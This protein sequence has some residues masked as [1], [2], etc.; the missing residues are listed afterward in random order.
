MFVTALTAGLD[1]GEGKLRLACAGHPP[2]IVVG[3]PA[4]GQLCPGPPLGVAPERGALVARLALS[5]PASLVLYT[6][7]LIEGRAA[8]GAPERFGIERLEALLTGTRPGGLRE[9]DLG[10][11][12]AEVTSANG[13]GLA[14]DVAVLVVNLAG[15]AAPRAGVDGPGAS[16]VSV[17]LGAPASG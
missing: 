5:P 6:D 15:D 13:E 11:L 2:P 4:E 17:R 1:T 16:S 9:A 8:P 3:T 12:V 14:D 7:G 10:D